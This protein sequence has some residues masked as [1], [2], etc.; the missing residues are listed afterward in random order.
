MEETL[1]KEKKGFL[2]LQR[3]LDKEITRS[4]YCPVSLL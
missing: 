1:G 4:S 2:F 3:K